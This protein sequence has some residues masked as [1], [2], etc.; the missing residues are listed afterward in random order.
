MEQKSYLAEEYMTQ[1]EE[2]L[3]NQIFTSYKMGIWR[4]KAVYW[5]CA[6]MKNGKAIMAA[7]AT[8]KTAKAKAII[9]MFNALTAMVIATMTVSKVI[10][11]IKAIKVM[12]KAIKAIF[13]QLRLN[14]TQAKLY[15]TTNQTFLKAFLI[16][17]CA[18]Q[19]STGPDWTIASLS[20]S[21]L[22]LF[23]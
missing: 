3:L 10:K 5:E 9:V 2:E 15:P 14:Q 6:A 20:W 22:S 4:L 21:E 8:F 7:K 12:V 23:N 11:A 18:C 19:N 17:S 13:S 16:W 1:E